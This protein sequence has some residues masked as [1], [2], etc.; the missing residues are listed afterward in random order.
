MK[1]VLPKISFL[2]ISEKDTEMYLYLLEGYNSFLTI[3]ALSFKFISSYTK[4]LN[5][6]SVLLSSYYLRTFYWGQRAID[7]CHQLS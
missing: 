2:S 4:E 7:G 3:V 6:V 5:A 1:M